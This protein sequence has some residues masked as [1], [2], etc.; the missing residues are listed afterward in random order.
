M[1]ILDNMTLHRTWHL[2]PDTY[3]HIIIDNGTVYK[4]TKLDHSHT[5][6]S[7]KRILMMLLR[8]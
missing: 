8:D 7:V 6:I 4:T 1:L 2:H 5:C 3:Y